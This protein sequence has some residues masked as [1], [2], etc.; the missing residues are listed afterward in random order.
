MQSSRDRG[1]G[2][3]R[4]GAVPLGRHRDTQGVRATS[5]FVLPDFDNYQS[6]VQKYIGKMNMA[7]SPGFQTFSAAFIKHAVL[8]DGN[9]EINVLTLFV[10]KLLHLIFVTKQVPADWKTAKLI[11]I[12]KKGSKLDP[13][14]RRT[15]C[16]PN[17]FGGVR[18]LLGREKKDL[19]KGEVAL[20]WRTT[21]C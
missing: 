12:Y 18:R 11:P 13:N 15:V 21:S 9:T 7:S 17:F 14:I 3:G 20:S 2:Y 8:Q 19:K 16:G 10:S 5:S 6:I 1:R 4:E